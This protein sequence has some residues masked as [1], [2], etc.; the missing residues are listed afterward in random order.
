MKRN[1]I[2]VVLLALVCSLSLVF[3]SGCATDQTVKSN[4]IKGDANISTME[5]AK[6][7]AESVALEE[8][9]LKEAALKAKREQERLMAEAAA[10]KEKDIHFDFDRYDLTSDARKIL[11]EIASWLSK[12]NGWEITI[13]G[14]CDNRGT[15][16][17]NLALGERRAETAKSYLMSLGIAEGRIDTISYGEEMPLDPANN[18]VAWAKN[19]RDH[20][21]V[22]SKK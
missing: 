4:T 8:D 12:Q 15:G 18:E 7:K 17:Y 21:L 22:V 5:T 1:S 16:E 2:I 10:F 13:Q 14:H 20:F 11:G 3:L 6:S 9:T 19:R